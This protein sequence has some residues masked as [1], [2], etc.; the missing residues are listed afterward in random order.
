MAMTLKIYSKADEKW[1][2]RWYS[3]K[4]RSSA[5][6]MELTIFISL[7]IEQIIEWQQPT[8]PRIQNNIKNG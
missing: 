8:N 4:K 5:S 6:I 3:T 1:Q 2:M 7:Q